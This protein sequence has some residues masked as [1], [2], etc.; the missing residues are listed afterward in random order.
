MVDRHYM[1]GM[2]IVENSGTPNEA[3]CDSVRCASEM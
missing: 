2:P 1:S 3:E